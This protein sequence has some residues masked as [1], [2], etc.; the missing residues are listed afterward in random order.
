ME[1]TKTTHSPVA[2]L[3]LQAFQVFQQ[4]N[5]IAKMQQLQKLHSPPL[6][7]QQPTTNK[8]ANP[9]MEQNPAANIMKKIKA[10]AIPHN[11]QMINP[12]LLNQIKNSSS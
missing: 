12:M 3:S 10:D 9:Y 11:T 8:R 1:F 6:Q 4:A 5:E 7:R 2:L